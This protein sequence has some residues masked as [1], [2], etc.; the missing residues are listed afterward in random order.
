MWLAVCLLSS[1]LHKVPWGPMT[2]VLLVCPSE[3]R[4]PTQPALLQSPPLSCLRAPFLLHSSCY[5]ALA[6][7]LLLHSSC[8]TAP[9]SELLLQSSCFR[10][11][12]SE[13]L[14]QSTCF[15]SPASEVPP[16]SSCLTIPSSFW[17]LGTYCI[18]IEDYLILG[19]SISGGSCAFLPALQLSPSTS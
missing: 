4:G 19:G 10:G 2:S 11:P 3:V 12:A 9:A 7:Q 18:R 6:T 13:L 17:Y 5:T 8:Y 14:L 16:L 15:R 1:K